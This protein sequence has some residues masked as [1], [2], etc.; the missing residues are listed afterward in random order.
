M[1]CCIVGAYTIMRMLNLYH[2]ID[3]RISSLEQTL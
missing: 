2:A 3:D 1:A